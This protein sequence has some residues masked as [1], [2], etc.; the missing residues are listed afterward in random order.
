MNL[1]NSYIETKNVFHVDVPKTKMNLFC[2]RSDED[3]C[4]VSNKIL[5]KKSRQQGEYQPCAYVLLFISFY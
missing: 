1:L 4:S 3:P 5:E 2:C